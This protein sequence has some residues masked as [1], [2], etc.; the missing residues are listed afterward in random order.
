[1]NPLE[2]I[3]VALRPMAQTLPWPIPDSFRPL[4][5]TMPGTPRPTARGF[6]GHR[7]R[8]TTRFPTVNN[9]I[10]FGQEYVWHCHILGHEE[11]DM[12]RAVVYQ[13]VPLEAPTNL[14]A[15][16]TGATQ[17]TLTF[18]DHSA[19]ETGFTVDRADDSLFTNNLTSFPVAPNTTLIT[20]PA[21][22]PTTFV[23]NGL[24]A[25][26]TYYYRAYAT[27]NTVYDGVDSVVGL[28]TAPV[29]AADPRTQSLYSNPATVQ[30]VDTSAPRITR[31]QGSGTSPNLTVVLTWTG[32]VGATFT[33]QQSAGAG[34]TAPAT[35]ACTTS[36]CSITPLVAGTYYF[37][38]GNVTGFGTTWSTSVVVGPP[39]APTNL[40]AALSGTT[41]VR[42]T[43]R[44]NSPS[45]PTPPNFVAESGFT[46]VR[47]GPSPATTVTNIAV[48]ANG[49]TGN[50]SSTNS[51]VPAGT[52]TYQVRANNIFGSSALSNLVTITR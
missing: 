51:P 13:I 2:D 26:K 5:T 6:I 30:L 21:G 23:N 12:M 38:V 7:P 41:G 9:K 44:D 25:G 39:A 8:T 10:N 18:A 22:A 14:T 42:L 50:M 20:G 1:M 15:A 37:R 29:S 32:P 47:V 27:K 48:G 3:I 35:L 43:W 34:F 11:N 17:V 45:S 46:I 16:Q 31:A 36:P 40:V 28:R 49:G 24:E 33:V 52:Y 19:S 4:D